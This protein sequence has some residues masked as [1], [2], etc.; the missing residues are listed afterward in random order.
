MKGVETCPL[1]GDWKGEAK[2]RKGRESQREKCEEKTRG[3]RDEGPGGERMACQRR[4][5]RVVR[6]LEGARA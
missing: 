6:Q 1:K 2:R 5:C 3:G 4:I